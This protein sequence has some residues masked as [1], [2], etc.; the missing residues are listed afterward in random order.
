MTTTTTPSITSDADTFAEHV[1][2]AANHALEIM[3]AYIG[4]RLGWYRALA[5]ASATPD[6]LAQRTDTHPR[7]TREWL[8]QQAVIGWVD[9]TDEGDTRRFH[10]SPAAAEVLTDEQSLLYLAPL[11]RMLGAF[12][13]VPELLEAYRTG[14][15][16]SWQQYGADARESQADMNRP[17]FEHEL[18]RA[19]ATTPAI[20]EVLRRPGATVA[21]VGFGA[22]WSSI[23]IARAYPQVTVEG[24]DT[25]AASVE[26]ARRNA[27]DAGVDDRVTF[28]HA[29]VATLDGE[30]DAVCF[31][32]CLHD[33]PHPVEALAAANRIVRPDGV[34]VVM[35]EAV[36][37]DFTAPGDDVER[38]M[39][40][41]S[42]LVC[43][44]DGMS[45]QPSAGTGT[46]FR[47]PIL[48]D[49]AQ[50]AGFRDVEVLPIDDFGFWR[51]YQLHR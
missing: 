32:E 50:T 37:D 5:E 3:G 12:V 21:D 18:P 22:G 9:V 14:G 42:M 38:L 27:V 8:E 20:D 25:D 1:F 39:Y 47:P 16:V 36:G 28:T 17:W 43:L 34:V 23:A 6:E 19:F 40:G 24:F 13:Q 31:F 44:P 49:Y 15:G 7:Y 45:H 26:M 11:A 41:L 30:Y 2:G 51:F 48:R 33:M 10:L 29:D 35:D 46:V 4:D